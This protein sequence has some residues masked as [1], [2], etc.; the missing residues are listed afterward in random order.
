MSAQ[1]TRKKDRQSWGHTYRDRWRWD[2]IGWASHCIDCYPGNCPMRVYVK[3][4]IALREEQCGTMPAIEQG[5]PD[6]N[7]M[8]CQKGVAW[9]SM[10]YSDERVLYP[11]KR[12]GERGSGK[13][14]RIT[15]DEA[16]TAVADSVLDAIEEKGPESIIHLSGCNTPTGGIVGRGRFSG[17]LGALTMDLNA[18][19]NDFAPGHYL[20]YGVFDPV[21]SIDDWFHSELIFIWFA[22]P[23]YTRIPHQ[24]Y[25]NEARYNGAEVVTVAP[26]VSP[27]AIH[28]DYYISVSPGSDAAFALGMAQVVIEEGLYDEE[29]M[30]DQ[31]DLPLLVRLDTRTYLRGNECEEGG[32]DEQFYWYDRNSNS[33]VQAPRADLH[34]GDVDPALEGTFQ[35]RLKDGSTVEV[36]TVFEL[37]RRRLNESY[38]PEQAE[39]QC[40][41]AASTMRD[42][43]RKV[44]SKRTTIICC[45][46]NASKYYHGDLIE[47]SEL[48]LLGLTGNWGKKG[49]GVRAW[50][51]AL[52][53]GYFITA[54]KGAPGPEAARNLMGMMDT[55]S[56]AV[57]NLD[58]TASDEIATIEMAKRATA[59]THPSMV[60]PIFLWYNHAGFDR[61]WKRSE[62]HDPSMKRPFQEYWDEAVNEGWWEGVTHPD[63]AQEPRVFIEMGGN[64]L[65]RTRGGQNMLLKH[66]WPKLKMVAVIDVRMSTTAM[67]ADIVLPAAQ[68]YEKIGFGI[69]STHTLNLT[70]SDRTLEPAGESLGEWAIFR[71]L[72]AKVEER[73]KARGLTQYVDMKGQTRKFEGLYD[74]F[75]TNGEF[76]EEERL[77]DEMVRDSATA[78]TLPEGS[79]LETLREKGFIRFTGLGL[80][81]RAK[82]QASEV[83]PDET[84]APFRDHVPPVEIIRS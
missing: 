18:E 22:N 55:M 78:G 9:A 79:S 84:F 46:G 21:S 68:Q 20:T 19:M 48:L 59:L 42:F 61:I 4:D 13:W 60:P 56:Q 47:R 66:L 50:L 34:L 25:I 57:R 40:G 44:A 43:G 67:Y 3:D 11:M 81:P 65:R 33:V 32:S 37:V 75:T 35:A 27:S 80:S 77:T 15:W 72:V 83:K 49:T 73:A 2:R 74:Q 63:A 17:L 82:G 71:D 64:A 58:P 14:K 26:D 51:G 53:D 30:K 6:M 76:H 54:G 10:H 36:T 28:A 39:K 45:L 23:A 16:L 38:T 62:W 12:D 29:F 1:E 8:G 52:F 31:T 69:P 5:V 70:F 7:P 24:H 41:V